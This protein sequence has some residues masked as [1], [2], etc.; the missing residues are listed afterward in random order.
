[1]LSYTL[2]VFVKMMSRSSLPGYLV[3]ET[4]EGHVLKCKESLLSGST[5]LRMAAAVEEFHNGHRVFRFGARK[6]WNPY[7]WFIEAKPV[8]WKPRSFSVYSPF[9]FAKKEL[10]KRAVVFFKDFY[11]INSVEGDDAVIV[12]F[13]PDVYGSRKAAFHQRDAGNSYIAIALHPSFKDNLNS[14]FHELIHFK[15]F[16]TK[17]M[18]QWKVRSTKWDNTPYRELP[19]EVE[20]WA[21]AE[22][23]TNQFIN[24]QRRE[25]I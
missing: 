21:M 22:V 24:E 2:P 10:I 18:E 4:S 16:A 14:L 9:S 20:A 5:L 3:V 19:W 15:Q 13:Y 25:V 6:P 1:M 8:G 17:Q 7:S 23:L 11:N 12:T